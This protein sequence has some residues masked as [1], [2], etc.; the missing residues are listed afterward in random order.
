M[1]IPGRWFVYPLAFGGLLFLML[2]RV[3]H[4][5]RDEATGHEGTR[6]AELQTRTS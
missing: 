2:Q 5:T 1:V 6:E 3:D 4:F